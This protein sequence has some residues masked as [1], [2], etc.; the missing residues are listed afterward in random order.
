MKK[1]ICFVVIMISILFL[2]SCKSAFLLGNDYYYDFEPIYD[3]HNNIEAYEVSITYDNKTS[4][5]S[6][7]F[8]ESSNGWSDLITF[9]TEYNGKPV[10]KIKKI[11]YGYSNSFKIPEG[12]KTIGE[13]AFA[14]HRCETVYISK[15][16]E[17]I[18]K[19]AFMNCE[20]EYIDIP[21]GVKTIGEYAFWNAKRRYKGFV[22][23]STVTKLYPNS[24]GYDLESIWVDELNPVYDSRDYCKS[25]I[26]TKTNY[27]IITSERSKIPDS[28]E[29]IYVHQDFDMNLLG[30]YYDDGTLKLPSN[31]MLIYDDSWYGGFI[32]KLCIEPGFKGL[33]NIIKYEL[34]DI[35]YEGLIEEFEK[36]LKDYSEC[37]VVTKN[38]N[39]K[40]IPN[41][42]SYY[43]DSTYYWRYVV[44]CLDGY[45]VISKGE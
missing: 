11:N 38:R 31:L 34:C 16:V 24:F 5:Y 22:I 23:P 13:Y 15:T 19:G 28:V 26:E 41:S 14:G 20:L 42:T 35:Y 40:V 17:V 10:T 7:L 45:V 33:D 8:E 30:Y 44:I 39:V 37:K 12:I 6:L 29:K 32:D 1:L 27:L 18:E 43:Q 21:E 2:G 3:V 25:V 9:P 4:E 36:D